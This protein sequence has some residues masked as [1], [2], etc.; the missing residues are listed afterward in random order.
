MLLAD[1]LHRYVN[2]VTSFPAQVLV[3]VLLFI[4][5]C[6]LIN[7]GYLWLKL[8]KLM[9]VWLLIPSFGLLFVIGGLLLYLLGAF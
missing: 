9:G 6:A 7:E 5:V 3:I 2:M 8:S 1:V 4:V